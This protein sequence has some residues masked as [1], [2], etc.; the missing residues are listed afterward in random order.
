V[1]GSSVQ[2]K[3]AKSLS[4][5][6]RRLDGTERTASEL[7]RIAAK[8]AQLAIGETTLDEIRDDDPEIYDA[9]FYN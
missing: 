3:P 9:F 6:N 2:W 5:I 1:F 4:H 8:A 7:K